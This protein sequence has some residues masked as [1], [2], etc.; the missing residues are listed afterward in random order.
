MFIALDLETTGLESRKDKIIEIAAIK[1]K[2]DGTIVEEFHSVIN[3]GIPIPHLITQITGITNDEVKN[4]P[5][6]DDIK[7]NIANFVGTLPILGHSIGFDIGFLN[8]NG[9]A[10]NAMPLDTFQLAQTLLLKE[11]SYSLEILSEKY[12]LPHPNKH[13]ALDDTRVAIKLYK[14]LLQKISEI[15]ATEIASI[16][17]DL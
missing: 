5:T 16:R 11:P 17:P 14:L 8:A 4:A 7:P 1:I 2:R 15:P 3:P 10:D 12:Q 9:L 6:L 13:R